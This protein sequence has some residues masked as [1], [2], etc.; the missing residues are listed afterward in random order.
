MTPP[1]HGFRAKGAEPHNRTTS[2]RS[3][4]KLHTTRR[5]EPTYAGSGAKTRGQG[6][7]VQV[8]W[9]SVLFHFTSTRYMTYYVRYACHRQT[10]HAAWLE[11]HKY[12]MRDFSTSPCPPAREEA[13]NAYS[14]VAV[15]Q[16]CFR[17]TYVVVSSLMVAAAGVGW[18]S[19][20][21]FSDY[22][23][24]SIV[25]SIERERDYVR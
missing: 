4:R 25:W 2:S 1:G 9:G 5:P 8:F 11:V 15:L 19:T 20:R 12:G 13:S 17:P 24:Y 18:S 10:Y 7:L 23:R 22:I 6:M 3:Q 21:P 14:T 16:Y